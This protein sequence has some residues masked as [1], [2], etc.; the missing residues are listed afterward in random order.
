V[1]DEAVDGPGLQDVFKQ[2]EDVIVEID[3]DELSD[4]EVVDEI[5]E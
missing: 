2:K 5:L 1:F 3:E 4:D